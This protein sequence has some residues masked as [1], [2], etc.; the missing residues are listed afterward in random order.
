MQRRPG[1]IFTCIL[2]WGQRTYKKSRPYPARAYTSLVVLVFPICYVNNSLF[3]FHKGTLDCNISAN[4]Q[5]KN[6]FNMYLIPELGCVVGD[7]N[8]V[9]CEANRYYTSPP[10]SHTK[11]LSET[12]KEQESVLQC[13]TPSSSISFV[14]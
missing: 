7:L 9:A 8:V 4:F 11:G 6:I 12:I 14:S 3:R 5:F 2:E 1:Q 13:Q 10:P